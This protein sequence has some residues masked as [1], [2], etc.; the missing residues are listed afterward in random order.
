MEAR[1]GSRAPVITTPQTQKDPGAGLRPPGPPKYIY[2]ISSEKFNLYKKKHLLFTYG[3]I[4]PRLSPRSL[5]KGA[6][7]WS[8]IS[9]GGWDMGFLLKFC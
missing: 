5:V 3:G 6:L 4:W 7:R 1:V 8:A 9:F 2:K